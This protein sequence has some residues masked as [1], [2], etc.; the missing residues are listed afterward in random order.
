MLLLLHT[1]K[2]SKHFAHQFVFKNFNN[3]LGSAVVL[4]LMFAASGFLSVN[5]IDYV[6]HR[7]Q[8]QQ[9]TGFL[10]E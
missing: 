8:L 9:L 5:K 1:R 3:S 2:Q 6:S 4:G 10:V 7:R